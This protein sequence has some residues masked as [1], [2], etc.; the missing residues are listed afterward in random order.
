MKDYLKLFMMPRANDKEI[1]GLLQHYPDDQ[2]A[3]CPFDT[4][5][6]NALGICLLL[7]V[8]EI[9]PHVN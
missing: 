5:I 8:T 9:E 4:G 3:G 2:R 1:D 6:K 7:E